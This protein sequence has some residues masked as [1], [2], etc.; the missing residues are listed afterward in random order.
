MTDGTSGVS[1]LFGTLEDLRFKCLEEASDYLQ[2][3]RH[4]WEDEARK[5]PVE[6]EEIIKYAR[7]FEVYVRGDK[8]PVP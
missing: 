1:K 7:A 8:V 3:I 2:Y 5:Q 6:P 4:D